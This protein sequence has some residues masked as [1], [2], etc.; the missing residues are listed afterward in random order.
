[1][2]NFIDRLRA[3]AGDERG[4]DLIEYAL[5]FSL[6]AIGVSFVIITGGIDLSIGSTIGLVGSTLAYPSLAW[7]AVP[8]LWLTAAW[9]RF[10]GDKISEYGRQPNAAVLSAQYWF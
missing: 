10:G 7:N 2:T 3:V 1:M 4:Q 6:I 9:R 5:L 8:D